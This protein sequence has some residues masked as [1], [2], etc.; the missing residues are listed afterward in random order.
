MKASTG[1]RGY[2]VTVIDPRTGQGARGGGFDTAANPYE[3]DAL[4]AY[5]ASIP[6]GRIVAV[7]TKGMPAPT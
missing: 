4:A 6:T 5:L 3:A 7:A 2:N 1:R